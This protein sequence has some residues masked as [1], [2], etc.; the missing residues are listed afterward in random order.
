M[1][2]YAAAEA[3]GRN[4]RFLQGA[5]TDPSAVAEIRQAL[6]E[7]RDLRTELLNYRKDGSSF[8]NELTISPLRDAKGRVTHYV[9][10]IND[11]TERKRV[12]QHLQ[13]VEKLAALGTLLSGVAHELNNPLFIISGYAQLAREKI[14]QGRY[15]DLKGDL[16]TIREAAQRASTTVNRFLGIGSR[17]EARRELC[18]VDDLVKQALDLLSNDFVIHQVTVRTQF[19][20]A[21]PSILA[22]SQDL[23][24]AFLNLFTNASQAMAEAHGRGTLS[25]SATLIQ[26]Q[27]GPWVEVRV[28][29]DGPGIAP[30]HLPRIFDPFY[31]TKPLGRRTGLGL[32]ISQRIVTELGGILT[33]ESVVGQGT[34]LIVRLPIAQHSLAVVGEKPGAPMMLVVEPDLELQADIGSYLER[35]GYC[36]TRAGSGLVAVRSLERARY[37]V[38]LMDAMLPDITGEEFARRAVAMQP[39]L[40]G[41]TIVLAGKENGPDLQR[42]LKETGSTAVCKPF[43]CEVFRKL[44]RCDAQAAVMILAAWGSDGLA[45]QARQLGVKD[46]LSKGLSLEVLVEAIQRTLPQPANAASPAEAPAPAKAPQAATAAAGDGNFILVVDDE[47]PIRD[48]LKRFLSLRGYNVRLA[49]DG[50]QALTLVE[51]EVPRLIVLDVYMPGMNGVEVLRQLRRKQFNVGVILLTASQDDKLLQEALDLGSV[52]IMGKPVD[53]ERLALAIQVCCILTEQEIRGSGKS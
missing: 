48:L 2:G 46:F 11:R 10:I 20:P 17:A 23:S 25:V 15:D 21:L 33:C 45:K 24:Q 30:E 37:D 31:T 36:V 12:E 6:K 53:L 5:G 34:S 19:D 3:L 16:E 7:E 4:C 32:T 35:Q 9:G 38:L 14:N 42:F 52:D 13:Q 40:A 39:W 1:T 41:R 50:Q 43:S 26:D 28:S 29:D 8:W 49:T 22:D 27:G 51:Q 47:E 44:R 18:R